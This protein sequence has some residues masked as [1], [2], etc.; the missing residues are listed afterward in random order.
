[1]KLSM[2]SMGGDIFPQRGRA[3]G[4]GTRSFAAESHV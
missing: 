2:E 3:A 4:E 1:M